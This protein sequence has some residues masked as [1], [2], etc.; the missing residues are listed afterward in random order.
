MSGAPAQGRR[1]AGISLVEL[2]VAAAIGGLVMAGFARL[3]ALSHATHGVLDAQS[4]MQETARFALATIARSARMA[5]HIG[6]DSR[7]AVVNG[8]NASWGELGRVD[9]TAPVAAY[10]GVADTATPDAWRPSLDGLPFGGVGIADLKPRSDI[11]VL[12]R[13]G[14]AALPLAAPPVGGASVLVVAAAGLDAAEGDFAVLADCRR[15][16][17]LRITSVTVA[18]ALATLARSPGTEPLDN[19]A[20]ASFPAAW[21]GGASP[22]GAALGRVVSDV[23]FVAEARGGAPGGVPMYA[24]WH[25]GAT[26]RPAEL[27]RGVEDLQVWLGVDSDPGDGHAAVDRYVAPA[28]LGGQAVRSVHVRLTA[29][30]AEGHGRSERTFTRT[31]ALR[32]GS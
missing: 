20:A 25:A 9:I 29:S 14:A 7:L 19:S 2:L 3:F 23:Y 6:C 31:V 16:A 21:G 17:L 32:S 13:T 22:E 15:A 1:A 12:R 4:R 10:D 26:S 24:L 30:S 11:L 8:L 28:G 18:G 27:A 5:G